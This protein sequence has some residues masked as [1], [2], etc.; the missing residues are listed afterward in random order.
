MAKVPRSLDAQRPRAGKHNQLNDID[1]ALAA[2][3]PGNQGL[4]TLKALGHSGLSQACRF[5]GVDQR[6]A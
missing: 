1:P 3:D 4:M 2:L 5:P 6:L